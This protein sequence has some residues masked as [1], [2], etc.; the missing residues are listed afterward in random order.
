MTTTVKISRSRA[1]HVWATVK[2][3]EFPHIV[4]REL[5]SDVL[6]ARSAV[7]LLRS[8]VEKRVHAIEEQQR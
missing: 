7:R 8:D 3:V 2:S 5:F 6:T 4:A 1:G